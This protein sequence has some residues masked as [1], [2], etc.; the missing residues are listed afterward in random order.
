MG[1]A[2]GITATADDDAEVLRAIRSAANGTLDESFF[3]EGGD[4]THCATS[5]PLQWWGVSADDTLSGRVQALALREGV[6]DDSDELASLPAEVGRLTGLRSLTLR[7][8]ANLATLPE[9]SGCVAL[10]ILDLRGCT[11][12]SGI[13]M[14]SLPRQCAVML[15]GCTG[16]AA[17]A[18]AP[19][20][21]AE[22]AAVLRA[23]REGSG[24]QLDEFLRPREGINY[25]NTGKTAGRVLDD[26]DDPR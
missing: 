22:Q 9:L 6:D 12:L 1:P 19:R 13:T 20:L 26:D 17:A 10:Q 7:G 25:R 15:R 14:E 18:G 2:D 11:A 21:R 24:G 4:W 3:S 23:L 16:I 5:S 8:C